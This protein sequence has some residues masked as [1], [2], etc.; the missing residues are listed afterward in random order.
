MQTSTDKPITLY[1]DFI[2]QPSRA[3][4]A[5]CKF[6]NIPHEVIE[7][8]VLKGQN[9]DPEY[10]KKN[11]LKKVPALKEDDFYLSESHTIMRYLCNTRNVADHWYPKHDSRKRALIEV[12]LDWHHTNTRRCAQFIVSQEYPNVDFVKKLNLNTETERKAVAYTLKCMEQNFLKNHKFIYGDEMTLADLSAC[13]E[14]MQLK[15]INFDFSPYP[16]V[17]AWLERC[18]DNA[19]MQEVH[20]TLFKLVK[21]YKS[22]KL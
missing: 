8:R 10:A 20:S 17:V 13:C 12:Y 21:L 16:I 6:N 19:V 14:I 2:S 11:P 4:L 7:T 18:M 15:M 1:V 5:F 22:P 3:V 9:R